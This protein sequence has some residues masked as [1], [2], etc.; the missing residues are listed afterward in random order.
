[1]IDGVLMGDV[2]TLLLLA[3]PI[4]FIWLAV[5]R[6]TQRRKHQAQELHQSLQVGQRVMTSSG[7]FG[8]VA[9]LADDTVWLTVADGVTVEIARRAVAVLAPEQSDPL[10]PD[11]ADQQNPE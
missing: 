9:A 7:L 11:E 6:P 5:V 3:L 10:A 4:F 8:V 2:I 1:M